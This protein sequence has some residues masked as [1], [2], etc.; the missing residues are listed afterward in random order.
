MSPVLYKPSRRIT[1]SHS[2]LDESLVLE[3]KNPGGLDS[4]MYLLKKIHDIFI[5]AGEE[6]GY[7][8]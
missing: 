5:H 2:V 3:Y 7:K 8:S 6:I 1:R 4:K